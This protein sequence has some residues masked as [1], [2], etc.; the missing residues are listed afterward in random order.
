MPELPERIK[1]RH[2][3]VIACIAESGDRPAQVSSISADLKI[4]MPSVTKLVFE[5]EDMQLVRKS[6]LDEDKRATVL[7]LTEKGNEY[8]QTYVRDYHGHLCDEL[9]FLDNKDCETMINVI[10][11]L[12]DAVERVSKGEYHHE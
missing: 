12:Y 11:A 2:I 3:H 10:N 1:P 7:T 9:S 4:T 5:L 8:Y 6:A